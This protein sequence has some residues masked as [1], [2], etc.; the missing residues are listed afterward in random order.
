VFDPVK[1]IAAF[2]FELTARSGPTLDTIKK[3]NEFL[4]SARSALNPAFLATT[5]SKMRSKWRE[6][7][8]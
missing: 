3:A 6:Q 4:D 8:D 5:T 7:N 1:S 2:K